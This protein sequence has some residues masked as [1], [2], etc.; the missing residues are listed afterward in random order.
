MLDHCIWN[1]LSTRHFSFAEGDELAKRYPPAVTALAAVRDFSA[2]SFASLGRLIAPGE[3]A[4]FFLNSLPVLPVGWEVLREV[5]L[6]QMVWNGRLNGEDGA[7][8]EQLSTADV[9][10][11][12]AL[13]ELTKPGPFSKRTPELG[14]YLGIRHGGHLVA[15]AGERLR[16]PGFTEVS[17]V[18]THPEF[19]GRGFARMLITAITRRIVARGET[20]FLHVAQENVRAIRVYENLGFTTR[21]LQA[22]FALRRKD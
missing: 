15:M 3:M 8:I 12:L 10:E 14:T 16:V 1:A 21:H 6:A 13:T 17:A 9:D 20:P 2:E 7:G 5:P 11:M 22:A 18:C 19:Q 4:I